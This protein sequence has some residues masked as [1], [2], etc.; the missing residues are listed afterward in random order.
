MARHFDKWTTI[1]RGDEEL[2]INVEF[3]A[4]PMIPATWF[5]P[6]EGGEI[7]IT[8]V[9]L[10]GV[11]ISPPL[12]DAEESKVLDYLYD[13]LDDRDFDDCEDDYL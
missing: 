2:E 8:A 13:S 11:A 1:V 3:T 6:A 7:E 12:T 9:F 5:D 10:D 4:T